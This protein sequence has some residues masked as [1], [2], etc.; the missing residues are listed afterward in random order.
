LTGSLRPKTRTTGI[1]LKNIRLWRK[2][3]ARD[4]FTRIVVSETNGQPSNPVFVV[5]VFRSGTSLL[6]SLLNQHP[7]IALMYECDVWDFPG[8][9]ARRRFSGDWLE[10]Q[11]FYNQALSRHRL[12]FG[13]KM[14]GLENIRTP[15]DLYRCHGHSKDARLWGEKSPVYATRLV[16]LARQY[17]H[18]SFILI[19]RDPVEVYRSIRV[20]GKKA[21]FFR[22]PGMLH[23]LIYHQ[24]KMLR[25]A[26]QLQ[27]SGARIHHVSY[28]NLVDR[29][30]A[31][32]RAACDFLG[33]PFQEEMLKLERADFSA[34]YQE[35]QH[36]F[37]RRGIIERQNHSDGMVAPA[38]AAKLRRFRSRW[39]RL[40]GQRL[41]IGRPAGEPEVSA[42]ER[43][44]HHITGSFFFATEN[45]KRIG[46]EFL[47]LPWLRTYRLFKSW[48]FSCN[49]PSNRVSIKE[50][51]HQHGITI[52]ASFLLWAVIVGLDNLT[53][54]E[55]TIGPL[56]LIP[57][58]TLALVV[59]CRWASVAAALNAIVI[60]FLRFNESRAAG[61]FHFSMD[62]VLVW[63]VFMRFVFFEVFVLLL[64]RIRVELA[65]R[66]SAANSSLPGESPKS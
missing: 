3:K 63:N 60:T 19:W 44:Y 35:P 38:E 51:T 12:I 4:V 47:P 36:E 59:G 65:M 30:E 5:G 27:R 62:A 45:I 7:Q 26:G 41:G 40:S 34:I 10:R 64:D 31:T 56:Y 58:A 1:S 20:A 24:E 23:R 50:Q 32:C 46:F 29:T 15:D 14:R 42:V 66:N 18:G 21:P 11:E 48:L 39:E 52:L 43:L 8:V 17:P 6:Y 61:H 57:C 2:V 54:P 37:L 22:R 49:E 25:E 9:G 55:I 16:Q 28:D 33:V 13:G 53:G